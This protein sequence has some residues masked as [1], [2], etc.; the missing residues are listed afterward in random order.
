MRRFVIICCVV[1]LVVGCNVKGPEL[2]VDVSAID[3]SQAA[4]D[5]TVSDVP[6]QPSEPAAEPA[7]V[8]HDGK[9]ISE[10]TVDDANLHKADVGDGK[11]GRYGT[12]GGPADIITAPISSLFAAK[13]M[14]AFRIQIPDALRLYRAEHDGNNPPDVETFKSA[15]LAPANIK[16]P[17]LPK[18][19]EYVYDPE[20]GEMMVRTYP[21]R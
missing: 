17:E 14:I 19:K 9:T 6:E 5:K 16:L 18:N 8:I 7:S 21:N 11:Q 20:S 13:E 1:C 12:T 15:I 2:Q 3:T 4:P 10:K